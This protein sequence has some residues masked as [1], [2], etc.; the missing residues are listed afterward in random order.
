MSDP[1][2]Q[3]VLFA[4]G[5]SKP[6]LVAFDAEAVSSDGG[7]VLLGALDRERDLCEGLAACVADAREPGK[8]SHELLDLLRQRVYS[9]ALGYADGNDAARLAGDPALKVACGRSA[10]GPDDLA[11][12]PTLSRFENA[13]SARE[14]LAMAKVLEGEAIERLARQQASPRRI[15][16]D[17][18]P[19]VDPAHGEQQGVLFNGFYDTHCY[20]PLLGFLS[21]EGEPDQHLFL[22]RLRPGNAPAHRAALR[23]LRSVVAALRR[24]FP[25]AR[26]LI[27]LDA[28]FAAPRVF[29]LLRELRLEYVV[30]MHYSSILQRWAGRFLS[31]ARGRARK[32]SHAETEFA[33]RRY[34][35]VRGKHAERV[36]LRAQVLPHPKRG[37]KDNPRFVA[38]NLKGSPRRVYELYCGRGESEN[39]IKELKH[40]LEIDRT[41]CS[42]FAANQMRVLITAAAYSLYQEMRLR[43][44]GTELA[45]AQV[46]R[47]RIAL[48][49]IGARV[50]ASARR[51][52]LHLAAAHPW[53]RLWRRM[54]LRAGALTG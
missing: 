47:L 29:S 36:I 10:R 14:L 46:G 22:A 9:Q 21:L 34:K 13:V 5:F 11:S 50:T 35:T 4:Q 24:R 54:A 52:V 38:T 42:R 40:D 48:L 27:R 32:S 53:Q 37:W 16:I 28:G 19:S 25:R 15:V 20:L 49:R 26:L 41:S 17:M 1:S 31:R 7:A 2:R 43:L 33:E 8:V 3:G 18:D 30:S 39:R 51:V 6:V 45:D 23:P 44:R 12:Q